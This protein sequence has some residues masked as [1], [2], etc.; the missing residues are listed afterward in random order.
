M[1]NLQRLAAIIFLSLALL[2]CSGGTPAESDT[3]ASK[4]EASGIGGSAE[5]F[6]FMGLA[7]LDQY[8]KDNSGKPTMLMFWT[9]WCP[10][11]KEH[12]PNM[13]K[14]AQNNSDTVNVLTI[15]LDDK[16]D[17]LTAFFKD[18]E[19]GVPVYFGDQAIAA[20]FGVEAIPTMVFFNKAGEAVFARPGGFPYDMLVGFAEKLAAE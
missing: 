17:A 9:T 7:E 15:S 5:S 19:P 4:T 12:F 13:V 10:S 6:P 3:S 16:R 11:C 2:A 20:K 14:L 18:K 8:L 1:K